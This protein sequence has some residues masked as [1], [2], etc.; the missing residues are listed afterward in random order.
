MSN[1]LYSIQNKS[2][3]KADVIKDH[4]EKTISH[5]RVGGVDVCVP[6]SVSVRVVRACVCLSLCCAVCVCVCVSAFSELYCTVEQPLTH[7]VG[8]MA[9]YRAVASRCHFCFITPALSRPFFFKF[10]TNRIYFNLN[11][12]STKLRFFFFIILISTC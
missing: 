11:C 5:L 2:S 8:R 7:H 6:L 1:I 3:S 12:P 9:S 4:F 10:R